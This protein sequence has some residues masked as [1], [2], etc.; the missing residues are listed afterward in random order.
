MGLLPVA[1]VYVIYLYGYRYYLPTLMTILISLYFS[2]FTEVNKQT[3]VRTMKSL[4]ALRPATVAV[5]FDTAHIS[6][7]RKEP[8]R[9]LFV[10][11]PDNGTAVM[12]K[13][14]KK[15]K[16][17]PSLTSQDSDI[18][19]HPTAFPYG[20]GMVLHFYQQQESSTTKTV[21]KVINKGL[22]TYVRV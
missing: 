16:Q 6:N 3:A 1:S 2:F 5:I 18:N 15:V 19:P 7:V 14:L 21:H 11:L 8:C 12:Q 20:N 4:I 22:K 9:P 17:N 13:Y 10:I